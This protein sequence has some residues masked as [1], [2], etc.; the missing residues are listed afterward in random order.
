MYQ[1]SSHALVFTDLLTGIFWCSSLNQLD[2]LSNYHTLLKEKGF[3]L[4]SSTI[5]AGYCMP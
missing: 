1:I 4:H 3:H 5:A 2:L